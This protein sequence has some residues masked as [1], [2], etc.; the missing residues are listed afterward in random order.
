VILGGAVL[1]RPFSGNHGRLK[2]WE[3]S[4]PGTQNIGPLRYPAAQSAQWYI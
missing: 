1:V 3:C 4:N 2:W